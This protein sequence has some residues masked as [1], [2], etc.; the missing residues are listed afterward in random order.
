MLTHIQSNAIIVSENSLIDEIIIHFHLLFWMFY[1]VWLIANHYY[2]TSTAV[3]CPCTAVPCDSPVF[4]VEFLILHAAKCVFSF[5]FVKDQNKVDVFSVPSITYETPHPTYFIIS[6][7]SALLQWRGISNW[8]YCVS[9][10]CN[11]LL[12]LVCPNTG[13][14]WRRLP[15][16][17][18]PNLA[19][20]IWRCSKKSM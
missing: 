19:A 6:N 18:F 17:N 4:V 20:Q 5:F 8:L 9:I 2:T 7:S 13:K 11:N 12:A 15:L 16:S 1:V 14:I 3:A 10:V